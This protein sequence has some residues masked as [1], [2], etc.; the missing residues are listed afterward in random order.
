VTKGVAWILQTDEEAVRAIQKDV[1]SSKNPHYQAYWNNMKDFASYHNPAT[2][3]GKP[4]TELR[5]LFRGGQV[6][7]L[8][9]GPSDLLTMLNDP[10]RKFKFGFVGRPQMD[11]RTYAQSLPVE[12]TASG[13]KDAFGQEGTNSAGH[14]G[15]S[16]EAAKDPNK[17]K[18]AIL[19]LQYLT[20]P[21]QNEFFVNE[22]G[23]GLPVTV[24]TKFR[25]EF[26]AA[27]GIPVVAGFH[28][29]AG[30]PK[31]LYSSSPPH[32]FDNEL[33]L[34]VWGVSPV[35]YGWDY[36]KG[37]ISW[38]EFSA[39]WDRNLKAAAQRHIA[40]HPEWNQSRW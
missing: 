39:N 15:I 21:E 3:P 37:N 31:P 5:D 23:I 13:T 27:V 1:F 11:N 30:F 22:R 12:W 33:E 24:G 32:G 28:K 9:G 36:L 26:N 10:D 4:A 19:W 8:A 35:G 40:K 7:L 29:I 18:Y 25:D 2:Y 14:W 20:A 6:A 34:G 16:A 17:L 38:Q